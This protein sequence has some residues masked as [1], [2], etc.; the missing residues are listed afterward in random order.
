MM[1]GR[2]QQLVDLRKL[3]DD[4]GLPWRLELGRRHIRV[5]VE[6]EQAGVIS[7]G[8]TD[9]DRGFHFVEK[10]LRRRRKGRA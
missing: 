5:I 3:L 8:R 7:Y 2:H 6:G 10:F 1:A 4:S 9:A